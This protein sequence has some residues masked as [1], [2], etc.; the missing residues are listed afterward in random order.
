MLPKQKDLQ[1]L[2]DEWH[3]L[4]KFEGK[5]REGGIES[6]E[7]EYKAKWRRHLDV[8]HFSRT[9]RL[10]AGIK[11]YIEREGVAEDIAIAALNSIYKDDSSSVANIMVVW[12]QDMGLLKRSVVR[13]KQKAALE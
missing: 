2:W 3:G 7:L 8:Q 6:I 13:G 10:I 1:G 4:R 5:P 9:K 11:A 12:V